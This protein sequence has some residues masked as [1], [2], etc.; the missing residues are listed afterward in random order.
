MHM[1]VCNI[2]HMQ[3]KHIDNKHKKQ[4]QN[5]VQYKQEKRKTILRFYKAI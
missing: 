1:Y 2:Y 5:D 3:Q 4:N